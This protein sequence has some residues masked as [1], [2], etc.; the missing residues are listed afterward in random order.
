MLLLESG[1]FN[2]FEPGIFDNINDVD[3]QSLQ[4]LEDRCGLPRLRRYP[5]TGRHGHSGQSSLD[6]HE[7]HQQRHERALL[8]RPRH[9]KVNREIWR[10]EKVMPMG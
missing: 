2:Q 1:H 10:L 7:F 4:S 3:T 9:G 8:H 6:P 5:G